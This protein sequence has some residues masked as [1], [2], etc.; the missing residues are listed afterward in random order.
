MSEEYHRT[1]RSQAGLAAGST[2]SYVSSQSVHTLKSD[3]LTR[4]ESVHVTSSNPEAKNANPATS[5]KTFQ[6]S[7]SLR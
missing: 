6:P 1:V 7:Y 5:K 2:C 4:S 3:S